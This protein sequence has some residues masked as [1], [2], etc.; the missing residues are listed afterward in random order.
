MDVSPKF[1]VFDPCVHFQTVI[2][3]FFIL[4]VLLDLIHTYPD[5]WETKYIFY[6]ISPFTNT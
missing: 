2:W 6:V 4:K 3:L 5:N 1:N